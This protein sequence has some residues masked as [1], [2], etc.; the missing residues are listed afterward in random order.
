MLERRNGYPARRRYFLP[1]IAHR[2]GQGSRSDGGAAPAL[3]GPSTVL[4]LFRDGETVTSLSSGAPAGRTGRRRTL[5]LLTCGAWAG[6][7]NSING[8]AHRPR[9]TA[10]RAVARVVPERSRRAPSPSSPFPLHKHTATGNAHSHRRTATQAVG[11][12]LR[13]PQGVTR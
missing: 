3:M 6:G 9:K 5:Y 13:E 10:Q 12:A 4:S 8:S 11:R 2:P 1:S 7:E